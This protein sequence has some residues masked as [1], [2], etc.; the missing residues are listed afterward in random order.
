MALAS[1][2]ARIGVRK[3]SRLRRRRRRRVVIGSAAIATLAV[4]AWLLVPGRGPAGT[5]DEPKETAKPPVIAA[6]LSS[7]PRATG[8][9]WPANGTLSYVVARFARGPRAEP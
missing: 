6:T 4:G 2:T 3:G 1:Q 5:P 9:G 8:P 7:A